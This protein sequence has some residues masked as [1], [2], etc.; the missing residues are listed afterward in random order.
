MKPEDE[1]WAMETYSRNAGWDLAIDTYKPSEGWV[2][3]SDIDEVPRRSVLQA[4]KDQNP[5]NARG[6]LNGFFVDG[7]K[8]SLGD[9]VRLQCRLYYYSFEYVSKEWW[10][11]PIL[12]RFRDKGSPNALNTKKQQRGKSL[13]LQ[14]P[15][16]GNTLRLSRVDCEAPALIG[17]CFHCSWCFKDM[18]TV[19]NKLVSYSH[20]DHNTAQVRDPAW[21]IDHFQIGADLI[22]RDQ[23]FDY[24]PEN[25][26]VP[27]MVKQNR[28]A[29]KIL[30]HG[31]Q[32]P[33]KD[34][35]A[36]STVT[37]MTDTD[38]EIDLD[39]TKPT[40]LLETSTS[41]KADESSSEEEESSDEE[42]SNEDGEDI[43][44]ETEESEE[45]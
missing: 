23:P 11:G 3:I 17:S 20:M 12:H 13:D 1:G 22:G 33:K 30:G 38:M 4:I 28:E 44:L 37:V 45:E 5:V 34:P 14:S 16:T 9:L 15:F 29:Y 32:K 26:D 39:A 40:I 36:F 2:I 18:S 6:D 27:E 21:I 31:S 8:D 41:S 25:Q 43:K 24:I 10:N 42:I 35:T 19:I 7:G